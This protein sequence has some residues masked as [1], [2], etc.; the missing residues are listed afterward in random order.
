MSSDFP[1]DL[2]EV[3]YLLGV[4]LFHLQKTIDH[5]TKR[6]TK[7]CLKDKNGGRREKQ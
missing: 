4:F 5:S 2:L 3:Q 7:I 6:P 1:Q